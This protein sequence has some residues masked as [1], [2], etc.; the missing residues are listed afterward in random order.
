MKTGMICLACAVLLMGVIGCER[1]TSPTAPGTPASL[2]VGGKVDADLAAAEAVLAC[3]WDFDPDVSLPAS[4]ATLLEK[5]GH[6]IIQDFQREVLVGDVVHYSL[7]L[8]VG[9]GEH[10]VIGLHRVVRERRPHVPIRTPQSLFLVHGMGKDFTGCFLPG[11]KSPLLPD[12]VGFAVFMAQHDID[13]WGIDSSYLLVPSGLEDLSFAQDWGMEKTLDNIEI[14]IAVARLTRLF[15]GNGLRKMI[16]LGYSQGM[17]TTVGLLNR[18][19]QLPPGRRTIGAYIAADAGLGYDDPIVQESDCELLT[20]YASLYEE[21]IYGLWDDPDG[22][23]YSLGYLAQTD[24]GGPSPHFDGYTNLEVFLFFTAAATPPATSH[25]WAASFD[26]GGYPLALTYT[27]LTA[28]TEFWIRW[29]PMSPATQLW[30]DL[31]TLLCGEGDSPWETRLADVDLPLFSLE[32]GGGSG[33]GQA[34]TLDRF[35]SADVTRH[36]VRL[37][38]PQDAWLDFG[39]V[40]LFTAE[41]AETEA[42]QPTL[43]WIRSLHGHGGAAEPQPAAELDAEQ[44]AAIRALEWAPPA[45]QWLG[46]A[47]SSEHPVQVPER[48]A[49]FASLESARGH[50]RWHHI[51]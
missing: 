48:P 37:E 20:G 39:H 34:S 50:A 38:A 28:A 25:Y 1:D 7:V 33:P 9:T 24:A 42:W 10:E 14:G 31:H 47:R 32:A 46:D 4:L 15:T 30:F 44:V 18:E 36:V 26:D 23:Y 16:L 3:G 21:G 5:N 29:A 45:G 40:D 43:T 22:F 6:G 8:A 12:D 17:H 27:T 13:V 49:R 11:R 2:E 19:T 35:A 41:N 51:R